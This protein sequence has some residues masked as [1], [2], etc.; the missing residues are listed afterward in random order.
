MGPRILALL[1]TALLGLTQAGADVAAVSPLS[2]GAALPVTVNSLTA[3]DA[4]TIPRM[5]SYQGRLTD[6]LG[7]PV[8]DGNYQ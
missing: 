6:T 2:G 1:I 4:I 5:L 3:T 7:N 8:P